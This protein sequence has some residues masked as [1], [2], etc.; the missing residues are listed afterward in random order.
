MTTPLFLCAGAPFS[1]TAL[2]GVERLGHVS[3]FE[4]DLLSP[5]PVE[6]DALLGQPAAIVLVGAFGQRPVHGIVTS[7]TALA[8]AQDADSRRYR[9]IVES[10]FAVLRYRRQSRIF[11]KKTVPDIVT[12]VLQKAGL[13]GDAFRRHLLDPHAERDHTTQYAEDDAAFV[14]RLCEEEGLYFR[15]EARDGQ[16][17]FVLEDDSTSAPTAEDAVL[18]LADGSQLLEDRPAAY[19]CVAL[20]KRSPGKVTLRDYDPAKP[21]LLLEGVATAG[22]AGEQGVEVYRAPGRFAT[23]A[24]GSARA[25]VLLE[26]LRA[27][28]LS[29]RFQT[30]SMALAPGL[31][32]R[33][34]ATDDYAGTARPEEELLVVEVRS[35]W[36]QDVQEDRPASI[37]VTAIP[38]GTRYRLPVVTPRPKISGI[39]PAIITGPS[40]V[41]IETD[42]AGH[43]HVRFPWD[44]TGPTDHQ[45]SRPVRVLQPS[46]AGPMLIPRVGWEVAVGFEDGDPDRPF[47]LGRAYNAKQPPPF[48]LPANKTITALSTQSSPG[49]GRRNAVHFDDAAGRQHMVWDA[50]FA[51]KTTVGN[52]MKTQTVG[53][54][55]AT[56]KGSQTRTVGSDETVSVKDALSLE[57]GSQ[58][59]TVGGSQSISVGASGLTTVGSESVLIGGALVEQ[60]GNPVTGVC[61]FAVAAAI[62]G[63]SAIPFVGPFLSPAAD[64]GKSVYDGYRD[65]KEQ[66]ALLALARSGVSLGVGKLPGG[67]AIVAAADAAGLTPWSERALQA[68]GAAAAGGG[69]S[70]AAAQGASG[71]A[72]GPGHR[73]TIVDGVMFEGIGALCAMATPGSIKWTSLGASSI[74]VG[75]SHSTKAVK[76]SR[77]TG[78][79]SSDTAAAIHMKAAQVIGRTISGAAN[80]S[81]AGALKSKAGGEHHIKAG[82]ALT[83]QAGG[84]IE[85][86]GSNVVFQVGGSIVAVHGGGV[87]L[88]ASKV[89]VNGKAVQSKKASTR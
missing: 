40:K 4:L 47:V 11:R 31:S 19:D 62:E 34:E 87:T 36:R 60:V 84:S 56:V 28:A 13:Q 33:L 22:L 27:E 7:F 44:R 63:S 29:Y 41:E 54:E 37:S 69:G 38:R 59:A 79:I 30:S 65:N 70:G 45:S 51:K 3:R 82:G 17:A 71:V 39:H 12:E 14:R 89:V 18:A 23:P 58:S 53:F 24:E 86:K 16:D 50:G 77:T 75:G 85:L 25:R 66:G 46:L 61:E 10:A 32:T 20:R 9:A 64:I 76:I 67:D 57:V 83:I 15:F 2:S 21:A 35:A 88:K 43:V 26:G 78:G 42:A 5:E 81:V 52:D 80:L 8:T 6:P 1:V 55:V 73:K 48:P 68:K 74:S 49:G 72:I